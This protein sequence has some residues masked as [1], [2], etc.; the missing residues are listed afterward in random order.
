MLADMS[1][2]TVPWLDE[3]CKNA[4]DSEV[5]LD[6]KTILN[7]KLDKEKNFNLQSKM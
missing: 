2:A 1:D 7:A 3:L 4:P 6:A 5:R